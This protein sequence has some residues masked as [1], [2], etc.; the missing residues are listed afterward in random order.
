VSITVPFSATGAGGPG[1][2]RQRPPGGPEIAIAPLVSVVSAIREGTARTRPELLDATGLSRKIVT[3]R[4]DQA[5][6][7]GLLEEGELAPSGGGRQARIVR[8]RAR[9]G[10]V[11]A[12]LLGASEFTVGLADLNGRLLD[13]SH[14]DWAI[15]AGPHATLDR[16]R[17]H[18]DALLRRH[19]VTRP[20]G[21]ALGLPGPVEFATG[22]V[23]L[24][25]IMPGWDGFAPRHWLREHFDAPVWVDND[26]NLMALGEWTRGDDV[27]GRDLLFIK[28]GTGIGAGQIAHGRLIHGQTG[29]AGDIGHIHVSDHSRACRCGRTG[30]LEAVAGGWALLLDAAERRAESP[31]LAERYARRGHLVLGDIGEA[32]TAGDPVATALTTRSADH[33][34]DVVANLVNFT[35]PGIVVLGGGVLRAGDV[36]VER[37]RAIVAERCTE[38]VLRSLEIRSASLDHQE[39]VIGAALMAAEN[40][41][42]SSALLR[43]VEGGTPF[44]RA[45]E[46]QRAA[47]AFV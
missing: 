33:V 4:V 28:V 29:A 41:F 27:R 23:T 44:G 10:V 43:W 15:D 34:A 40:L 47:D 32:V 18:I 38:P 11:A 42:S 3:Q 1:L 39:G 19:R 2:P 8:F 17:A 35:N 45:A 36:L 37:V 22:T 7:L 16:V 31:F 25:P 21:I 9:S 14:E 26:V 6:D 20:W 24:P 46:I 5:I 12:A 13:S 30:C